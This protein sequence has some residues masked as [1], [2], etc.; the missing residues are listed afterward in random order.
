M[1]VENLRIAA[2][3]QDVPISGAQFTV[4]LLDEVIDGWARDI[5]V[6]ET[7]KGIVIGAGGS[8]LKRVGSVA[9]EEMERF[10]GRKIYLDLRV[11]V[12]AA[13]KEKPGFLD[14]LDW[15]TMAG[16]DES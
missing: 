3:A 7:Q 11:K 1:G 5:D 9:R 14:A 8:M 15:R 4:L 13:W 2:P 10:F 12:R 16:K 6:R